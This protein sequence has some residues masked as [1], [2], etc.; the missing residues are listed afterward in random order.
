MAFNSNL[1]GQDDSIAKTG[2]VNQPLPPLPKLKSSAGNNSQ[3]TPDDPFQATMNQIKPVVDSVQV[4]SQELAKIS[5]SNAI[6]NGGPLD[7]I[8]VM[9]QSLV[10]LA[11]QNMLKPGPFAASM[12]PPSEP[13][14]PGIAPS[15]GGPGPVPPV[16]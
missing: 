8:L 15:P 10:P 11:A 13:Q 16:G 14:P 9:V 4:I 2:V 12:P 7:Q 6:P 3:V 1:G 5:R